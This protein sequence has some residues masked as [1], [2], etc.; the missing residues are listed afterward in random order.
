M[1]VRDLALD[2]EYLDHFEARGIESLYPPQVKA[3]EAGL[4]DG[5][6]IV[7]SVPTASGKTL[8][9]EIAMCTAT[10]TALYVVPLRALAAE[11]H[12]EFSAIPGLDVGIATGD[13]DTEPADLASHDVIVATSEKV[14]SLVRHGVDWLADLDCLAIDEVHLLD[15]RERGPTLEVTVAKV[16]EIAPR[17]Q[18]VALSATIPNAGAVAEWLDATLV[19]STW[20][21][22]ELRRSVYDGQR[23]VFADGSTGRIDA[24]ANG[25]E[26]AATRALVRDALTDGGQC[27]V[28]VHSRRA[29]EDL[30]HTIAT[31]GVNNAPGA[32]EAI[33]DT[34]RTGTGESLAEYVR[35]GVAFHHAGLRPHHRTRVEAAFRERE[36]GIVCATPTLAAGVNL[37]ARRVVVRDHYRY[38]DEG[39]ESLP[40]LE[41]HQMFGRA[42]RPGLDPHGEAVL[43]GESE[44]AA[45][46]LRD[47][48]IEGDPSPVESNLARQDALRTHVLAIVASGFADTRD[49]LLAVLEGTFYATQADHGDLVDVVDLLLDYLD[50]VDMLQRSDGL[51]ATALGEAVSRTYVDPRTAARFVE[52]FGV[53]TSLDEVS[54]LTVLEILCR[55]PEMPTHYLGRGDRAAALR[56]ANHNEECFVT[57]IDEI[58]GKFEDWL[59]SLKA[60]RVLVDWIEDV[61]EADLADQHGIG[62][63][64][65]R[66]TVERADW[67]LTAAETL[68][69]L[70]GSEGEIVTAVET[71]QE[72]IAARSKVGDFVEPGTPQDG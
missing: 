71:V 60:V 43:V 1:N 6:S 64:D 72:G 47:R 38:T 41:V 21:P 40:V 49:D 45:A 25:A 53:A 39:R 37:P 22:I 7:A 61:P 52:D 9:A 33:A 57:G 26:P 56:F 27:L 14:D 46:T 31:E 36:I 10:G 15:S 18:V 3:I 50:S 34:A 20:R 23:L 8:L 16:C 62:P 35:D 63:G 19:E 17:V 67:L 5:E 11:K 13:Y 54:R 68:A 59:E 51:A 48:Y 4:L 28:F 12:R 29:A 70:S 58:E 65:L 2:P 30:A 66:A 42:G 69:E 32:A 24:T 55:A 44:A